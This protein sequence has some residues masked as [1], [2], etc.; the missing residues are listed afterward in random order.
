MAMFDFT[1][2]TDFAGKSKRLSSWHLS[3]GTGAQTVNFRDGGSGGT[4]KFQVQL[5][6]TSSASQ[7]YSLPQGSLIFP[8][9]LYVEVVGTGFNKGMVNLV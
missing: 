8:N 3:Q 4:I 5:A 9:S 6:A 1:A 2:S 7:D